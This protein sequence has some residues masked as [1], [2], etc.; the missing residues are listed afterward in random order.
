MRTPVITAVALTLLLVGAALVLLGLDWWKPSTN[1]L[2]E[3][4]IGGALLIAATVYG[5][6]RLLGRR[7]DG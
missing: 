5:L 3:F 4:A 7:G 2:L 1:D 6:S